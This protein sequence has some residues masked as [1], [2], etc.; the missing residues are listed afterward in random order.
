MRQAGGMHGQ[1][2]LPSL[3]VVKRKENT[4]CYPEARNYDPLY[5]KVV[6][7]TSAARYWFP[8]VRFAP[9][10][11]DPRIHVFTSF[12]ASSMTD[13]LFEFSPMVGICCF[14]PSVGSVSSNFAPG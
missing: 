2:L 5:G 13:V 1:K 6:N 10:T 4:L 12:W 9:M 7:V 8:P 11:K 14:L 3:R